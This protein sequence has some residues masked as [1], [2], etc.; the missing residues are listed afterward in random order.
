MKKLTLIIGTTLLVAAVV[1]PVFGW[2]PGGGRGGMMDCYYNRNIEN[3][4]QFAR[5]GMM[6]GYNRE[7]GYNNWNN[8]LTEDQI[9]QLNN[10][11]KKFYDETA[12]IREQMWAKSNELNTALNSSEPDADRVKALQ[13]EINDLR[14]QMSD[15]RVDYE[16][17]AKK[18]NPDG[19]STRGVGPRMSGFG[20]IGAFG[21]GACF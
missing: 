16:L 10:L 9:T 8:N 2:G 1:V 6:G 5:G 17:E 19:N 7:S 18:I 15:A 13:A 12:D 3:T 20:G 21:P 4:G 11:Q 14:A